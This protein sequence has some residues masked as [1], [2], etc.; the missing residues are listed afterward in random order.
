[1]GQYFGDS[2]NLTNPCFLLLVLHSPRHTFSHIIT[3]E[4]V[5]WSP[6]K[7]NIQFVNVFNVGLWG[8]IHVDYLLHVFNQWHK[9]I[10][11][12]RLFSLYFKSQ[13]LVDILVML[14]IIMNIY[15]YLY[16][17]SCLEI[18]W[19]CFLLSKSGQ[20]RKT[21]Q[22]HICYV[23]SL[24]QAFQNLTYI[25]SPTWNLDFCFF[26]FLIFCKPIDVWIEMWQ[27]ACLWGYYVSFSI[28]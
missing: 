13:C 17:Y 18:C 3:F 21:V 19:N 26:P 11:K 15:L 24:L 8:F 12:I 14:I 7:C 27:P 4:K 28:P 16:L 23:F 20:N 1:M 5:L 6:V 2:W 10:E 9:Q 25:I 22:I